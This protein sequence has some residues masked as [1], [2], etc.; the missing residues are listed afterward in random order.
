MTVSDACG[1]R[2]EALLAT[3]EG[4]QIS[5]E[6]AEPVPLFQFIARNYPTCGPHVRA[7]PLVSSE[8][9]DLLFERGIDICP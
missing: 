4:T 9:E 5:G 7:V 2:G 3:L 1:T 6:A 8:R